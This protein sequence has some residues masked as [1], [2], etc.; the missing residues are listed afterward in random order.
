MR[1]Q[2]SLVDKFLKEL[3]YRFGKFIGEQPG[4]FL[5]VPLLIT[6]LCASGFQRIQHEANPE[7]LF[8]PEEG[9]AKAERDILEAHFPTNFTSFDPTR[10]SRP[11]RFARLLIT[12]ADGGTLLRTDVWREILFLDSVVQNIS[13]SWDDTPYDYQQLCAIKLDGQCWNNEIL[14]LGKFM[15]S[16]EEEEMSLAYPIWFNPET[17]EPF[18]FPMFFGGIQLSEYNTIEKVGAV[19]LAYFLDSSEEWKKER[20]LLWEDAFL[21]TVELQNLPHLNVTRFSS[22]TLEQEL[23]ENTNSV[24][25]YFSLNIGIMVVFC[26]I[27]C[28]M[29][30]WVKSKPLL[31]LLGVISAILGSI[32]A[33]GLV[34]Y[35]GMDF[36]GINLAAPFLMLG[37]GIDDT[38]VMLAAWRKTSIHD[39]VPVRV[40][41]CYRESVV[42]ITITSVTDML[43]FWIGVIT[44]FPCVKIFCVYTGA[45]VVGTYLWHI[46]FFG[47]CL[48]LAGYAEKQNR[49]AL[50]CCVV[51]PKSQSGS[52]GF[53]YSVFCSGGINKDDPF[54]PQDNKENGMMAFF[55]DVIGNWLNKR[56]AKAIVLTIFLIYLGVASWGVTQLK[57]GLEK[58]R[59]SRFDSYSVEYYEVEDKYF[60]EYPFR[61]NVVVSGALDYSKP[62][63]QADME[64]L[65]SKLENTT[66]IDPLYTESW[67]RSF[68]DYVERWK[69]YP[70]YYELEIGDEQSFIKALKNVYLVNTPFL[71]D[72]DFETSHCSE[73]EECSQN[74]IKDQIVGARFILQGHKVLNSNDESNLV[75]ELRDICHSSKYNVTV[76]HPY[77]IYFDQFLVV[78]PTTIQCVA[79]AAG[80]MMVVS[81]IFIPN[82]VC[83]LWVAFSIVSIEVG[84][85]GFMTFWGINLDSI[86]MINLIM[87]IGFSVDFTAHISY[88]YLDSEGG[89]D[90]RVRNSLYG[91]GLPIL[92]GAVSTVLGVVGLMIAPSYIFVTFFKMVFLVITLGFLHGLFLLPVL[93]S[94][95]GPGSCSSKTE[96]PAAHRSPTTSYLSD[97]ESLPSKHDLESKQSSQKTSPSLRIPRPAT[98]FEQDTRSSS[99]GSAPHV[100]STSAPATTKQEKGKKR[101]GRSSSRDPAPPIHEMYHNNGYMSE[102][103]NAWGGHW[104]LP[105]Q[106]RYM[107]GYPYPGGP[108]QFFP[109][110]GY[111][112]DQRL[113]NQNSKDRKC[114]SKSDCKRKKQKH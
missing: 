103:E 21:K 71:Q 65:L 109:S 29:T 41:Q 99:T 107:H 87:C 108:G 53:L 47:G 26:I 15:R 30:D 80:V 50:T 12:A 93:L 89:P 22:V 52:K 39:P 55:R 35:L 111:P 62:E 72:I 51:T 40:G 61:I 48:A 13:I 8:S 81:L 104:S 86:S 113:R 78:L 19:S 69:D 88:H 106:Q 25:P 98:N 10:S 79:I 74:G 31:G 14:Q 67:L 49:H 95:F 17:F 44:P 59:L 85:L 83:S 60:R 57:E 34:M 37:I 38:F 9:P 58:K 4:Y 7:Y 77:F 54:N 6:A 36:I 94:I 112:V 68:L 24:I 20:G 2:L 33:F 96:K 105:P 46:T 27:T 28:M 11:G 56:Y 23:E 43:S 5:I 45:C 70:D 66:Y 64:N 90:D 82:P 18:T 114:K 1:C 84:V 92:Q 102:E 76:F 63:V 91:L 73:T 75:R 97:G 110:Y 100:I 42:S 101:R 16:I 32:S 3:F